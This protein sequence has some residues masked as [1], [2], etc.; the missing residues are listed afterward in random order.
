MPFENNLNENIILIED[1]RTTAGNTPS[2]TAFTSSQKT[3]FSPTSA[4]VTLPQAQ[5]P[6]GFQKPQYIQPSAFRSSSPSQN[7]ESIQ[8]PEINLQGRHLTRPPVIF[9]F[10]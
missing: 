5:V 8:V 6:A 7:A 10:K 4:P 3:S 1:L 2:T 9:L